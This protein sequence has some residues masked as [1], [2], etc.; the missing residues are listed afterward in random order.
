MLDPVLNDA[1]WVCK[2]SG[3]W[4]RQ[5][6]KVILQASMAFLRRG[7]G[8]EQTLAAIHRLIERKGVDECEHLLE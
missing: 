6:C 4:N 1:V 5:Q 8:R 3:E 7:L 2:Q